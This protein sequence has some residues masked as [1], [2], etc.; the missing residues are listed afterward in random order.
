MLIFNY[1][2]MKAFFSSKRFFA[3]LC[4]V[5]VLLSVCAQNLNSAYF[6]KGYNS[7]SQLNPA[8]SAEHSF[9]S[10]PGLGNVNVSM[11]GNLGVENILYP[12]GGEL[13]T[14]M[15]SKIPASDV[16][17][18]LHAKNKI[19]S[20]L[21]VGVLSAGFRG[22]GGFNTIAFNVR[23]NVAANLP[24]ELFEFMKQ[25]VNSKYDIKDVNLHADL[26]AELLIGHSHKIN[27]KLSVGANLKL[28]IGGGN[29][30]AAINNL[31]AELSDDVWRIKGD[32]RVDASL[33]GFTFESEERNFNSGE[34]YTQVKDVDV[35]K[36]GIGGYGVAVDLGVNYDLSD[37]VEGLSVNAAL[38]DLGFI[39]W[40][41]DVRAC[42]G[43]SEF[44][45][46][47]FSNVSVD[48]KGSEQSIGNQWDN[49]SDQLKAFAHLEDRGNHG[50]RSKAIGATVNIGAEY[51]LPSYRQLAF[52]LLSSTRVNGCYS[53]TEQRL[54]VNWTPA[55]CLELATGC[56][57][58]SF[59]TSLGTV[60]NLHGQGWNFTVGTDHVIGKMSKEFIP[61]NSRGSVSLGL[62]FPL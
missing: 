23:S 27:D 47:G 1:L 59:G 46:E 44:V 41:D 29:V 3:F 15:S 51:V 55:K 50:P 8:F 62:T 43:S 57:L 21:K 16:L 24:Y 56:A 4:V 31:T 2:T 33:N 32:A 13:T 10:F 6:L 17:D 12:Q 37:I 38:L 11:Q 54:S 22:F 49:I 42:N 5:N 40:K 52:G 36:A 30:D 9:F 61:L 48:D 53:W 26:Y 7:R 20:N 39:N 45:F 25:S 19:V 58:S 14:F 18:G 34:K 35:K 60:L 28:L